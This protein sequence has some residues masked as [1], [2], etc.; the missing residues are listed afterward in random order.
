MRHR[1]ILLVSLMPVK[2]GENAQLL[3]LG[4]SCGKIE[5]G[6]KFVG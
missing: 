3:E 1:G 5:V 2:T 6:W 4:D